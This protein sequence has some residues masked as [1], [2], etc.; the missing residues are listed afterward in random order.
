MK[1]EEQLN[2]DNEKDIDELRNELKTQPVKELKQ[3]RNFLFFANIVYRTGFGFAVLLIVIMGI[4]FW[5]Y[6]KTGNTLILFIGLTIHIIFFQ[7]LLYLFRKNVS[8]MKK[9]RAEM[10]KM[11]SI[12]NQELNSRKKVKPNKS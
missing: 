3:Y 9:D 6:F 7:L 4:S 11:I 2:F 1:K 10:S 5:F 8:S 12:L